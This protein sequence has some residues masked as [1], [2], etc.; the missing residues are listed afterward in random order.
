MNRSAPQS[1][2]DRTTSIRK[3]VEDIADW[4][5]HAML[6]RCRDRSTTE[7]MIRETEKQREGT[8]LN[9]KARAIFDAMLVK[10]RSRLATFPQTQ[11]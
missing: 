7:R 11:K 3:D 6:Q 10:L 8:L 9:P 1:S 2:G 5:T 4:T